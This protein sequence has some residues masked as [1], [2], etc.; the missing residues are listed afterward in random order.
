MI[1]QVTNFDVTCDECGVHLEKKDSNGN[2]INFNTV[3]EINE[4]MLLRGWEA[5]RP[6]YGNAN[7]YCPQCRESGVIHLPH[8]RAMLKAMGNIV[9]DEFQFVNYVKNMTYAELIDFRIELDKMVNA[10]RPT[11]TL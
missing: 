10:Y 11:P 9:K 7:I 2:V 5:K 1:R 8:A 3:T 4:L 6:T